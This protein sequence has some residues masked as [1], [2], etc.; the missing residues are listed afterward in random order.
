MGRRERTAAG[1][2]VALALFSGFCAEEILF[3]SDVW[4]RGIVV[5]KNRQTRVY[6][7]GPGW[8]GAVGLSSHFMVL[9]K[10]DSG[11]VREE[12]QRELYEMLAI[13]EEVYRICR[14]TPVLNTIILCRVQRG[15][16]A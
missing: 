8:P 2:L 3:S 6:A 4:E 13:G 9:L 12:T 10:T 5:E 1:L 11:V 15:M 7:S 14:Q 16:Q